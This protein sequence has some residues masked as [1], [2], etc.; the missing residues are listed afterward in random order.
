MKNEYTLDEL[1]ERIT[2]A[3]EEM[4]D[5]EVTELCNNTFGMG[6]QYKGGGL[7]EDEDE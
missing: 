1:I 3:V 2:K 5:A 4:A 6:L 7:W